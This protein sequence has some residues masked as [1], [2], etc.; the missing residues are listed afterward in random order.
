MESAGTSPKREEIQ[1]EH[2]AD[3]LDQ[4]KS[5]LDREMVLQVVDHQARLGQDIQLALQAIEEGTYGVCRR[6]DRQIPRK[7][8]DA[9][10]WA[11]MCVACQSAV[12]ALAQDS[13]SLFRDAA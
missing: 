8:L 5:N 7:R 13:E 10:P 2:L 12:E 1:I 6:C 11:R 9:V 3:P 4:I